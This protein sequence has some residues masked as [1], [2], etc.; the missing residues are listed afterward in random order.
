MASDGNRISLSRK[1]RSPLKRKEKSPLRRAGIQG[2]NAMTAS[3][4]S[5]TSKTISTAQRNGPDLSMDD[6]KVWTL[7]LSRSLSSSLPLLFSSGV[8]YKDFTRK[9]LLK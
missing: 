5:C 7:S 2:A 4:N 9:H 6:S 1:D 8:I 3:S